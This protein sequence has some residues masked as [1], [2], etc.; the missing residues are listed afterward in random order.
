MAEVTAEYM[1]ELVLAVTRSEGGGVEPMSAC[2]IMRRWRTSVSAFSE[3]TLEK[4]EEV[5]SEAEI[6]PRTGIACPSGLYESSLHGW[7]LGDQP[8]ALLKFAASDKSL[9]S[10]RIPEA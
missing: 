1:S 6:L 5:L 8:G 4:I 2:S 7:H 10:D 9:S 3:R